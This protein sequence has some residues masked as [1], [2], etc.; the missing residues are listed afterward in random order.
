MNQGR[1]IFAQIIQFLWKTEFDKAVKQF[2]GDHRYKKFKAWNHLL[3]LIFGQINGCHSIR[4]IALCLNAHHT[5]LYHLGIKEAV[6]ESTIS[7]ANEHRDWRIFATFGAFMIKLVKPYYSNQTFEVTRFDSDIFIIDSTSISLSLK[8]CCWATGKR[9]K[10]GIKVHAVMSLKGNIP[11]FINIS[12]GNSADSNFLDIIPYEPDALYVMDRAYVDFVALNNIDNI[13]SYFIVR[14]KSNTL[15]KAIQS[16]P[17]DKS[18][19]LLC[20]QYIRLQGRFPLM[21]YAKRLRRIKYYDKE[22]GKRLVFFTNNFEIDALEITNIY[23]NRWQIEVFFKWIKQ[24][25]TIKH[26]WGNSPNAV[27]IHIWVAM[28]T[29]LLLAYIKAQL[30]SELS[31]SEIA[32]IVGISSFSKVPIN[33]LLSKKQNNQNIKERPNLFSIS[34]KLTHQ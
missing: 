26:L 20:D 25:L 24:N 19:G 9:S 5:A 10:G 4:D 33:E 27:H 28:I 14:S 34:D 15:Y 12:Q 30:K 3:Q 2:N 21:S 11:T 13:G 1:Y 7:R 17:V 22:L 18:T 29:Y 32:Q 8:L 23:R 6:D 31:I 16:K